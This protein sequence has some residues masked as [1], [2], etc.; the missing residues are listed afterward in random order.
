MQSTRA[1]KYLK[2]FDVSR[3]PHAPALLGAAFAL[4]VL[5]VLV[6]M[7]LLDHTQRERDRLVQTI[8]TQNQLDELLASM[9]RMESGQ[10]GYLLAGD[11]EFLQ[12]YNDTRTHVLD[13][14]AAIEQAVEG[15]ASQQDSVRRVKPLIL[16]KLDE[17]S[18]SLRL[19]DAGQRDE[20]VALVRS[21]LGLRYMDSIREIVFQIGKETSEQRRLQHDMARR[22]EQWLLGVNIV[23]VT[24]ILILAV[25]SLL[26]I[27]RANVAMRRAQQVLKESN[28]ELE[29]NVAA[30]TAELTAA[31]EEIQKFAYIVS[32]DLRSPLVNIMGFTSELEALKG[33]LFDGLKSSPAHGSVSGSHGD[34]GL[35]NGGAPSTRL[36][37]DFDE[38]LNFIKASITKMDRLINAVLTISREGNRTLQPEP[39]DMNEMFDTITSAVAHQAQEADAEINVAALPTIVSDRLAIEQVFSNLVDNALKYLRTG[40]QGQ[41][42]VKAKNQGNKVIVEI[43]DNGR[44]IERRDQIRIFELFRRAGVQDRP[45]EGMGLAHV[46]A[47]VRRLGGSIAVDSTPGEGSVFRVAL[48][49]TLLRE[50]KRISA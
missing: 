24:L 5:T 10:R 46:R 27:R 35:M 13:R 23:S 9:R 22:Q 29:A 39:I 43:S 31:N 18:E 11:P 20:A 19:Y 4:L 16:G 30:R 21:G 40:V 38:A 42:S 37:E 50:G 45:G 6:S 28:A 49:R 12:I 1:A 34:Q 2:G 26:V 14:V 15:D 36:E 25:V 41:I 32:H 48:P 44:G 7:A 3:I 33:D 8:D 17:M 47:L